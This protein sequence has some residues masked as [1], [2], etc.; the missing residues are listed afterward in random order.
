MER[1]EDQLGPICVLNRLR[2]DVGTEFFLK[3]AR[4]S[5]P[6]VFAIATSISL[7]VKARASAVPMSPEPMIEYF[8]KVSLS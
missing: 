5:G 3:D 1:R 8:I 6:R 2:K 4:L 7:R